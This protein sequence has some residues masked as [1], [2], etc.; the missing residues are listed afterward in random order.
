MSTQREIL[1]ALASVIGTMTKANGYNFNYFH[2]KGD[3][4]VENGSIFIDN[5][6]N[7]TVQVALVVEDG[8]N[9]DE[10]T[11]EIRPRVSLRMQ[12][13]YRI[14]TEEKITELAWEYQLS[15]ADIKRDILTAFWSPN[16]TGLPNTLQLEEL[17]YRAD[18]YLDGFEKQ[19]K[20]GLGIYF[21]FDISYTMFEGE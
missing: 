6:D 3:I 21:D 10:Y 5:C 12:V 13:Y 16:S 2:Y 1:E 7:D 4:E 17:S 19:D 8:S 15:Y 20:Y 11:Q 14:P 9:N 18:N